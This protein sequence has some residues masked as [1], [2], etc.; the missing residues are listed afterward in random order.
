[1]GSLGF[2]PNVMFCLPVVCPLNSEWIC[3]SNSERVCHPLQIGTEQ[4]V[5]VDTTE[6]SG[7]GFAGIGI[8]KASGL[9]VMVETTGPFAGL[10]SKDP[11]A[12]LASEGGNTTAGKK[13]T[14]E[15]NCNC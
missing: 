15:E 6:P 12:D 5:L 1:M 8:D 11:F 10:A 9:S 13:D 4:S 3:P 2:P 7:L 14:R